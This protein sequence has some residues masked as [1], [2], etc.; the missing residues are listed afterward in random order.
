[1]K[2][3]MLRGQQKWETYSVTAFSDATLVNLLNDAGRQG[4]EPYSV[5][6]YRDMKGSNAWTAFLKRPFTGQP[7]T[8]AEKPETETA[9]GAPRAEAEEK[10]KEKEKSSAPDGWDL[11]GD[12]FDIKPEPAKTPAPAKPQPAAPTAKPAAPPVKKG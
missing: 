12:T 5:L 11:S 2:T 6:Y 10:E 4:W 7:M 3:V 1:M 8:A 9:Q